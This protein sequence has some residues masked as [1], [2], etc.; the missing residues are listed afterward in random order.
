MVSGLFSYPPGPILESV[1]LW[2][3]SVDRNLHV[4]ASRSMRVCLRSGRLFVAFCWSHVL[5]YLALSGDIL[6]VVWNL[7]PLGLRIVFHDALNTSTNS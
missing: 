1:F 2:R 4:V 5:V 3:V 6:R 7:S